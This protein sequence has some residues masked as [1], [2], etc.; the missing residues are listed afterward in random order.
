M[1]LLLS[2]WWL[3]ENGRGVNRVFMTILLLVPYLPV[4]VIMVRMMMTMVIMMTF[5]HINF[6]IIIGAC[7]VL[8]P[9]HTAFMIYTRL[10]TAQRD[11][12]INIYLFIQLRQVYPPN[13]CVWNAPE[14]PLSPYGRSKKRKFCLPFCSLLIPVFACI[15]SAHKKAW[16]VRCVFRCSVFLAFIVLVAENASSKTSR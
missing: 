8:E 13:Y 9:R 5:V 16:V 1:A 3:S 14:W 6:N 10:K 7:C 12:A 4:M 11:P 15:P 2:F